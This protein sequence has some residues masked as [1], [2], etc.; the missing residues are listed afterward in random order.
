[1]AWPTPF[2]GL[3]RRAISFSISQTAA[4]AP[5]VRNF[6]F[7]VLGSGIAGLS[8][9]L[10][11]AKHGSVA[12]V[13]K[14]QA[15]E[16]CTQY[17]QGGVC[18]VLGKH[19]SV[20]AHVEDTMIAGDHLSSRRVVEVVCKEGPMRV[21]E[22]VELGAQFTR[23][24]NGALHLTREGGHS[25]RRIVHAAD[26]TGREIERA[27]LAAAAAKGNITFFEHHA[28]VDLVHT[29]V[30]GQKVCMGAD[31]LDQQAMRMIRF[32]APV[33]MLATG[34]AGQ[35]YP[36]TTNPSVATGDGM[37]MAYRAKATVANMEFVQFHPT[38]F[39]ASAVTGKPSQGRTFLISEALRGEG[40]R[41]YNQSGHRF[42]EDYDSRLDLAPRDIVA[43]AIQDQMLSRNDSHVLLDI[44]YK[45]ADEI[46]AHFPNIA[47]QC[48]TFGI[49]ITREPIPVAP[50]QHY[51]C[52]GVQTGL[53]GETN[54]AGLFACGEVSCTG[55]HG[56]N[57]LASNS[58]LEGL[59]FAERA[60]LPSLAHAEGTL[61]DA[62]QAMTR[63]S[64]CPEFTG[65][66][67]PRRLSV[68]NNEWVAAKRAELTAVM[69]SAAG[70]V[71]RRADMKEALQQLAGMH[72]DVQAMWQSYGTSTELVELR[73]LMAV[74]ELILMSALQRQESRGG[75]LVLDHPGPGLKLPRTTRI[76]GS[77]L[78][79]SKPAPPQLVGNGVPLRSG[80]L[81]K[82]TGG[83]LIERAR[84]REVALKSQ[85]E[86]VE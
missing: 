62:G 29:E 35:V 13:T 36:N 11:V 84:S 52:G 74:G 15:E 71:R 80:S 27:L 9:A 60:V 47:A 82:K 73:N 56:A 67:A 59:V 85:K 4:G 30:N 7:L 43:R 66:S 83:G 75:H 54:V 51:M 12:V 38:A 22:L 57:R 39:C 1:M 19:D 21:M 70:I 65:L 2:E 77:N 81:G 32:M 46:L 78:S 33:T 34:G 18:A 63:A 26:V 24:E 42:M 6:D 53:S 68:S 48:K 41:L 5:A 10:K 55:L 20:E 3:G 23:K 28:A 40:G 17:A 44:S 14:A 69:W 37:A 64:Q 58:L 79:A 86:D 31:V 25:H 8:Y 76:G 72:F 50:A 16:G 49:D 61:R 45:P